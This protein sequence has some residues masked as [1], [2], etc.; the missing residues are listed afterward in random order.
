MKKK[1]LL[2]VIDAQADFIFGTLKVQNALPKMKALASFLYE[3]CE[4]YV[5]KVC[6]LDWHPP[7]HCSFDTNGGIWPV[8]CLAYGAGAG[9]YVPLLQAVYAIK[10]ETVFLTKG[11]AP[12]H[13]E[14]SIFDN[15]ES[16]HH[17]QEM[18]SR[19]GI[20]QIDICGIAREYCVK[21]SVLGAI[22]CFGAERICLL[23][24]YIASIS[25]ETALAHIVTEH[26]LRVE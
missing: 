25:D 23:D 10:G 15:A 20:E 21:E 26:R 8:H 12:D 5:V 17:L 2:L 1:K 7:G 9:I 24:E 13:E 4:D 14:Y 18:V 6:T 16:A 19:Y 11:C 3:H 22:R